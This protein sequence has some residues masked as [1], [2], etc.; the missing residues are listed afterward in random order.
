MV[1]KSFAEAKQIQLFLAQFANHQ[2]APANFVGAGA[3]AN[4]VAQ[5]RA[6]LVD[7]QHRDLSL[8]P[9]ARDQPFDAAQAGGG[10]EV[11]RLGQGRENAKTFLKQNPA[12]AMD[13]EDKIRAANGL[14]F[15]MTEG[16]AEDVVDV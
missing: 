2:L 5:V 8:H 13:I 15:H 1:W 4:A 16:G 9:T 14:D 7:V 12:V 3:T 6:N 10:R 11:Q